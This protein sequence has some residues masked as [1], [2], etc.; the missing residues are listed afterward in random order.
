MGGPCDVSVVISTY[1][2]AGTLRLAVESLAR[3]EGDLR[4]EVVVVDNN[5]TDATRRVVEELIED[6]YPNLRYLFEPRLGVSYGRNTGVQAAKAP[7]IA[8]TDDDLHVTPGWLASL[9]GA[10]TAHP[11]VEYVGGKVLPTSSAGWPTWVT[12]EHWAPLALFD[13]GD[14][15]FYVNPTRAV[16]LGTSNSAYRRS[17]FDRV[18]Y[19]DT[20]VQTT[21]RKS[22]TEDHELQLRVWRSG[23]QGLWVPGSVVMSDVAS[24]R[25]TKAYHRQWQAR[26]GRLLAIMRDEA[27][28][29]TRAGR[30]LGVPGHVYRRA[31]QGVG[32]GLGALLR[33]DPD[34]AFAHEV[35]L[36]WSLGFI[37]TRWRDYLSERFTGRRGTF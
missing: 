36:R 30:L 33:G 17:V 29:Q 3:Q 27:I 6:G 37:A 12:R 28:E 35:R 2:R 34:R 24:D 8:F 26:N 21:K 4:Y 31:L 18:G 14:R 9:Y 23:G 13:Y 7:I 5:S 20:R 16:C 11:E 15:P 25:L 10:L 22:A 19:F 1:N 32:R